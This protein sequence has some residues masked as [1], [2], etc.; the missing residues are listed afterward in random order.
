LLLGLANEF[1]P[2]SSVWDVVKT[3]ALHKT[4]ILEAVETLQIDGTELAIDFD[5]LPDLEEDFL[6]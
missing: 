4:V 6:R 1:M 3:G 5:L 2:L